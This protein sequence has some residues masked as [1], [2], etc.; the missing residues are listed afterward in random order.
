[1]VGADPMTPEWCDS[2]EAVVTGETTIGDTL[3]PREGVTYPESIPVRLPFCSSSK[4]SI[5]AAFICLSFRLNM[6][7]VVFIALMVGFWK[8][9]NKK[10]IFS[11]KHSY[12]VLGH[13]HEF[14]LGKMETFNWNWNYKSSIFGQLEE[15]QHWLIGAKAADSHLKKK[16]LTWNLSN[17]FPR[18]SLWI[19]NHLIETVRM[20]NIMTRFP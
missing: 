12:F 20:S 6:L 14:R 2:N 19:W 4:L 5:F 18:K 9:L 13:H 16:V 8:K 7:C 3:E 15:A 17:T 10:K 11:I 1:M